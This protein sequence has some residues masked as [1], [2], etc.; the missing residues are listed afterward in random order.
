MWPGFDSWTLRHMWIEFVVGSVLALRGFSL[1]TPVFPSPQKPTFPNSIWNSRATGLSVIKRS[2]FIYLFYFCLE[3]DL[4][5][6]YTE[7]I[8]AALW[9]KDGKFIFSGGEDKA[10][11][12]NNNLLL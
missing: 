1:G 11:R 10:M 12:C 9:S 5:E 3:P 6:G 7:N 2:Q 4:L 8:R